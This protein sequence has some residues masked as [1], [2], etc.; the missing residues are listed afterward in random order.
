[1]ND[2]RVDKGRHVSSFEAKRRASG[3]WSRLTGRI[4]GVREID[5]LVDENFPTWQDYSRRKLD[6][7]DQADAEERF[8]LPAHK[9]AISSP[10]QRNF[11]YILFVS[12]ALGFGYVVPDSAPILIYGAIFFA[13]VI[14]L[15]TIIRD[16]VF[17]HVESQRLRL[18]G[19]MI[20]RHARGPGEDNDDKPG[21]FLK[22]FSRKKKTIFRS[23][24]FQIHYQNVLRTFEQGARRTWV[25]QDASIGEIQTL[26]SQRGMKLVWTVI[27]VLPQLGLLGTLVGLM[28]MFLA[29]RTSAASPE[30]AVISGF[31][32]ALGTTI[33]ANLFVLVLRPLYMQNER[34]MTEILSTL[35]TLMA[36]FI[37]PT[38]H[39]AMAHGQ[40]RASQAH[41][42]TLPPAQGF[43][44]PNEARLSKSL[45]ELAV[46][47]RGFVTQQEELDSGATARETA[48]I[49]QDVQSALRG[50][51]EAVNPD[52]L[53]M[54]Q[55]ALV[56]LTR[57]VQEMGEKLASTSAAQSP[58]TQ[59]AAQ[60]TPQSDRIEH[61]LTQ[62][63]VLTR[64]TLVLLE[65]IARQLGRV[66][67]GPE[68]LLSINA[69]VRKQ[70]FPESHQAESEDREQ[71]GLN[72]QPAAGQDE[73]APRIRLVEERK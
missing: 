57:S 54:Q 56:Q 13:F 11:I 39:Y 68:N 17:F 51:R 18:D 16:G 15:A 61:D 27:E 35:Q 28:T 10:L 71:N 42:A 62:L 37:L 7:S 23:K 36:I 73:S 38:Q 4:L 32:T 44:Q 3:W 26:L 29:F 19:E 1:M 59:P 45:E 67:S 2:R 52:S 55:R 46:S 72:R 30:L 60:S 66:Q 65:Q 33:L 6:E 22:T 21:G 20:N 14:A 31:G 41:T 63:R 43:P 40:G 70:I 5:R 48:K 49:A 24:L 12:A 58:P 25:Y 47:I 9:V 34:S 53:L 50:F 64:D 69:D 8:E